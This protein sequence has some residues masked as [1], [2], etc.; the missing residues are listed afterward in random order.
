M[1][2]GRFTRGLQR[3]QQQTQQQQQQHPQGN[4]TKNRRG[5]WCSDP[6][7]KFPVRRGCCTGLSARGA[8]R[9]SPWPTIWGEETRGFADRAGGPHGPRKRPGLGGCGRPQAEQQ[10]QE[11]TAPEK[12]DKER[13][14]ESPRRS[15]S[16]SPIPVSLWLGATSKTGD[17]PTRSPSASG[18][19]SAGEPPQASLR[20][21]AFEESSPWGAPPRRG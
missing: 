16:R 20:R 21:R 13:E 2:R 1:R 9:I 6:R 8:G 11:R 15:S 19:S 17:E 5:S 4:S 7:E 3:Q 12:E 18:S 10:Q 14:K